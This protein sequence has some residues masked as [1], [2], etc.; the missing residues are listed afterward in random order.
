[1][2]DQPYQLM[3]PL[4]A[5][6][7]SALRDDIRERG[8]MVPVVKD[9]H[10]NTLDGHHRQQIADE[11]GIT[12]RV[13]IVQVR[14]DDE[15]RSLARMYNLARR[16][17]TREQKRQLIADE[18]TADPDR[19]DRAI[20]RLLGCDHKTVGSVRRELRGEIP[21]PAPVGHESPTEQ[22]LAEM[23]IGAIISRYDKAQDDEQREIW[24]LPLHLC[25]EI[26]AWADHNSPNLLWFAAV[27]SRLYALNAHPDVWELMAPWLVSVAKLSL[28]ECAEARE[29]RGVEDWLFPGERLADITVTLWNADVSAPLRPAM[30]EALKGQIALGLVEAAAWWPIP[31]SDEEMA[32]VAQV[33]NV[34][35]GGVKE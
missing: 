25:D 31:D 20:A 18:I 11:L 15:A 1:M 2:N 3:P 13:D 34:V 10:G 8:V 28:Q 33:M 35:A 4:T 16:H 21:H 14:D 19:S 6:E 17:L 24:A 30:C 22:D 32:R 12:Y 23:L 27:A 26:L 7:Y 29:N 5:E 9:Q